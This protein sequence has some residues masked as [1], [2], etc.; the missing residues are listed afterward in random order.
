MSTSFD[1]FYDDLTPFDAVADQPA[2]VS[3]QLDLDQCNPNASAPAVPGHNTNSSLASLGQTITG[4][5]FG[6]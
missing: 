4:M 1:Q 2:S 6:K 5:I 3:L